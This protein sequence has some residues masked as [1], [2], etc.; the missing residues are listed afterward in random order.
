[1]ELF[2]INE[3]V[4]LESFENEPC[5]IKLLNVLFGCKAR[6]QQIQFVA[7][8]RFQIQFKTRHKTYV[9]TDRWTQRKNPYIL[10]SYVGVKGARIAQSV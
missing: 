2:A 7:D 4:L 1:M 5:F 9:R 3:C 8:F 10:H 6:I